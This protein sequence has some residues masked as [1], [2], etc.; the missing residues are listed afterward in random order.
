MDTWYKKVIN[1]AAWYEEAIR[2][3]INNGVVIGTVYKVLIPFNDDYMKYRDWANLQDKGS[4]FTMSSGDY[5][6]LGEVPEEVTA[7]NVIEVVKKY[8]GGICTVKHITTTHKRFG[9]T[10]QLKIEGV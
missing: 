6:I 10:V 3:V 5:I 7:N 4:K 9:A 1:N 8:E 2:E